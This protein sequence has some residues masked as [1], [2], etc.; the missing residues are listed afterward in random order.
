MEAI[1]LSKRFAA[2]WSLS[3]NALKQ[4]FAGRGT[5][6]T[7]ISHGHLSDMPVFRPCGLLLSSPLLENRRALES[8]SR[9]T[10]ML[11][12]RSFVFNPFPGFDCIF[13]ALKS[14]NVALKS[15]TKWSAPF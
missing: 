6:E 10:Q 11:E 15:R 14:R 4:L 3:Q 8:V 5:S 12:S 7:Q 2:R 13:T 9:C 1:R